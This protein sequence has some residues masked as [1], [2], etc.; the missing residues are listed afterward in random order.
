MNNMRRNFI[1]IRRGF[2]PL[3]VL[4]GMMMSAAAVQ[5]APNAY[6]TNSSSNNVSVIDTASNT[7]LTR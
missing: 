7:A 2:L 3:L 1:A 5:A 4:V 6:V